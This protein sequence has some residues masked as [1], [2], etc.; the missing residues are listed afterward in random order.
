[1]YQGDKTLRS[2]GEKIEYTP[3]SPKYI[4][5]IPGIGYKFNVTK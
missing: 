3:D 1:M 2:Q 4:V 5:T